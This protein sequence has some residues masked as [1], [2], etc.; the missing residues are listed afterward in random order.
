MAAPT[1]TTSQ[2]DCQTPLSDSK[3]PSHD[4]FTVSADKVDCE[5]GD[6]DQGIP[7]KSS[8]TIATCRRL[9]RIAGLLSLFLLVQRFW[10]LPDL[11]HGWESERVI[12]FDDLCP[13]V[14]PL[15][16]AGHEALLKSLD[17]EYGSSEFKLKAY[18]S[19]GG[20]VRI[21]T[22]C[23]DDLGLPSEDP[24]WEIEAKFHEY[25]ESRF[26][27][28]HAN[29]KRTKVNTYALVY[30][31]KG[32]ENVKPLLLAAH[33]DVV[34][35]NPATCD[36]WI[37]PPYSGY[38]DGE[39][40][41]GRGSCDDKPG[42]TGSLTAVET[43]LERGFVP[44]RTV[45]LAFGIDEE[46][47]GY[48]GAGAIGKYLLETHGPDSFAM[49][50]D[51][52]GGYDDLNGTV[53]ATPAVAE[54]GYLDIRMDVLTPG[55][56]SSRP[57]KHTGIGIL[58]DLITELEAH[59]HEPELIR[60]R[61]YYQ[62][63]E[64]RAR[65]DTGFPGSLRKLVRQSQTSDKKLRELGD[66]LIDFDPMFYAM[67]GTT[68][69]IDLIGGGVKVNALPEAVWAVANYR[70]VDHSSPAELKDRT[71]DITLPVATKHNMT[72][73]AF[74]KPVGSQGP[75]W[76][77][78]HLSVAFNHSLVPAPVTPTMGSGP[79]E[80]LSGTIRSTFQTHLRTDGLPTSAIVS[81]GVSTDTKHY[82]NLTKHIFRYHHR[83]VADAYNG[84]HTI[85][86][87][88]RA[89]GFLEQI[90]FFTRLILNADQT[91]LLEY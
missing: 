55:G 6:L 72:V 73:V 14:E 71:I 25:L 32:T 69:A 47:G 64:C 50:V 70:I 13:Q 9:L 40:I 81:P 48:T 15:T 63:L 88:I 28:V 45:L 75:S 1:R 18:E 49:I 24:R 5:R 61:T 51:E 26:P 43:L 7:P 21:P 16:P 76:G 85:N 58:A 8:Q 4:D 46:R 57:P 83:G 74:G 52:G 60:G 19:L 3:A 84:I 67:S 36:D 2:A 11:L 44:S 68:Q 42:V 90:R 30:E 34:P 66:R 79:Y 27:M 62:G 41:W 80:L 17:E 35:V 39:W 29:L 77:T 54:K 78:I 65:Y 91:D 22:E 38:Y 86:E 23:Y 53:F 20:A 82:W 33:M 10:P 89:E 31:W 56:H 59:P 12:G 37:H 87:A